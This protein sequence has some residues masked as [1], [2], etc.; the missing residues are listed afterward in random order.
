MVCSITA[1]VETSNFISNTGG[2]LTQTLENPFE[3]TSLYYSASQ[4]RPSSKVMQGGLILQVMKCFYK[5]QTFTHTVKPKHR[6]K[7]TCVYLSE[8][9]THS[10]ITLPYRYSLQGG[11][12]VH[13][14]KTLP[15]Y[16]AHFTERHPP[17]CP[18]LANITYSKEFILQQLILEGL[19]Q[20]LQN[21]YF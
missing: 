13:P 11:S 6:P 2:L 4:P 18:P 20:L 14:F 1:V 5:K 16:Q 17:S 7:L 9:T 21:R 10:L 3:N 19:K 15:P 12:K 8:Q